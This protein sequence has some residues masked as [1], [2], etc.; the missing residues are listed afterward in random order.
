M[1][2]LHAGD[3]VVLGQTLV[4][5]REIAVDDI[6]DAEV[7]AQQ[8]FEERLALAQHALLEVRLELGVELGVGLGEVDFT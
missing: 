4:E 5:H 2:A 8:C 7:V 6:A 1:I 3:A